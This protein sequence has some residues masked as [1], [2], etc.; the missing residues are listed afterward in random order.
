MTENQKSNSE[1]NQS[2]EI[3]KGKAS[4]IFGVF[5][6]FTIVVLILV[7]AFLGF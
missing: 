1:T 7:L 6:L 5:L 3:Y 2:K 4:G